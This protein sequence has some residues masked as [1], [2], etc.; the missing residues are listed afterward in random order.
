M[1][2]SNPVRGS[3]HDLLQDVKFE[4]SQE[5]SQSLKQK[6]YQ[7]VQSLPLNTRRGHSFSLIHPWKIASGVVAFGLV[8]ALLF[9]F[10]P[11]AWAQVASFLTGFGVKVPFAPQGLVLSEF[12]PLAPE[13]VPEGMNYFF[14]AN[15]DNPI[16]TELRYFN[17]N[18]F[19]IIS[20]SPVSAENSLPSGTDIQIGS[21]D[22]VLQQDLQGPVMLA[23]P[24]QQP[25]RQVG[26]GSGGGGGGGGPIEQAPMMM[27]YSS[28]VQLSWVQAD[29]R[30]DLLTNL[31]LETALQVAQSMKLAES[32]PESIGQ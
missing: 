24:V 31:P 22:A 20:E 9:V 3:V 16:Y 10:V 21:Y 8:L 11:G 6:V 32:L 19:M 1:N 15:Y 12:T 29:L 5:F 7:Q 2:Q 27:E 28:G 14:S 17:Q 26:K 18:E 4:P 23:A 30:I 13:T 25:W